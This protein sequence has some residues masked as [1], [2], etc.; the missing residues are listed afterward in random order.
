MS[1]VLQFGGV[2]PVGPLGNPLLSVRPGV[3]MWEVFTEGRVP[4]EQHQNHE[5]VKLV[6][7]GHRLFR[8]KLAT[9]GLYDIMQFCWYEVRN[10]TTTGR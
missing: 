6:S 2:A 8:P 5:V 9:A 3:L 10:K 1:S 4:F 7:A